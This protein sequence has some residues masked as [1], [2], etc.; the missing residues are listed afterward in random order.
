MPHSNFAVFGGW[1]F[2]QYCSQRA[3]N[4]TNC[5]TLSALSTLHL[6]H[7]YSHGFYELSRMLMTKKVNNDVSKDSPIEWSK[8][9]HERKKVKRIQ[10]PLRVKEL[11]SK[12]LL[13]EIYFL[14]LLIL[15]N[16]CPRNMSN[17]RFH[18]ERSENSCHGS[19]T[20]KPHYGN[21]HAMCFLSRNTMT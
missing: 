19:K 16:I 7:I 1:Y 3:E 11:P 13:L 2:F 17:S 5:S 6:I 4:C 20:S 10:S 8:P 21:C 9:Y 14:G 15:Q 18:H 12:I